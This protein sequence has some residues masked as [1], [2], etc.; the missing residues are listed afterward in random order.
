MLPGNDVARRDVEV[1]AVAEIHGGPPGRV[2]ELIQAK[3]ELVDEIGGEED[4]ILED[5]AIWLAGIKEGPPD[6]DVFQGY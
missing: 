6:A 2:A 3:V 1:A 5:Q 4:V